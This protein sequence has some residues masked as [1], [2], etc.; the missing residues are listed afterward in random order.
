MNRS[1]ARISRYLLAAGLLLAWEGAA[2]A[3]ASCGDAVLDGGE[4]CDLGAANGTATACCAADCQFEPASKTCRPATTYCD[5]AETCTGSSDTCPAD[6]VQPSGTICGL[7]TDCVTSASC[8]GTSKVCP[9]STPSSPDSDG[10]SVTSSNEQ[11]DANDPC[12]NVGNA[13][14]FVLSRR[15]FFS[16]RPGSMKLVATLPIATTFADLDPVARGARISLIDQPSYDHGSYITLPPGTYAGVGTR[17][18]QQATR[19]WKFIDRTGDPFVV[20]NMKIQDRGS[21]GPGWVI[22][23]AKGIWGPQLPPQ[24]FT[25]AV[26]L[27]SFPVDGAAGRCGEVIFA[28]SDCGSESNLYGTCTK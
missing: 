1:V 16:T 4:A 6:A 21:Q 27:G 24:P 10:D 3:W 17:G 26:T 18:W 23:K 15:L 12:T 20:T 8:D 9:P 5:V 7:T 13:R 11:C 22:V 25:L 2:P 19:Q 14:N 28:G